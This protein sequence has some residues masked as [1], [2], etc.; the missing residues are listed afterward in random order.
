MMRT[1]SII[2]YVILKGIMDEKS[3]ENKKITNL[4]EYDYDFLQK[5]NTVARR[6]RENYERK[7]HEGS[8]EKKTN[9]KKDK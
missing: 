4:S 6:E 3:P 5:K 1:E 9:K 7:R 2:Y 8:K